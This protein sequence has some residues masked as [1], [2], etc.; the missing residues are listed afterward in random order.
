MYMGPSWVC[1][2]KSKISCYCL[3]KKTRFAVNVA[4]NLATMSCILAASHFK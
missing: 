3:L 4:V 2:K 1:L